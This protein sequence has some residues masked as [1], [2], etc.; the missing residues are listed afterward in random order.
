M[1]V[2][3]AA[4]TEVWRHSLAWIHMILFIALSLNVLVRKLC[5]SLPLNQQ[6]QFSGGMGFH[7]GQ[8]R[9]PQE[10]GEGH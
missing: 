9:S 1:D 4:E 8:E 6:F 10:A 7:N 2:C 3:V 5:Q